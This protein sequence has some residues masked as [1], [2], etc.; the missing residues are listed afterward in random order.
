M[1]EPQATPAVEGPATIRVYQRVLPAM[2]TTEIR[3]TC[4]RCLTEIIVSLPSY[5]DEATRRETIHRYL[6][7]H[8]YVCPIGLPE[9]ARTYRIDYPRA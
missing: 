2:E 1:S 7:A 9:E 6:E 5:F 4:E 3:C 8:R